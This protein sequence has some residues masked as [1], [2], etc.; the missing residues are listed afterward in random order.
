MDPLSDRWNSKPTATSYIRSRYLNLDPFTPSFLFLWNPQSTLANGVR[1]MAM[2]PMT[3]LVFGGLRLQEDV[4]L[5]LVNL[6]PP[7]TYPPSDRMVFHKAVLEGNQWLRAALII[8][9]LSDLRASFPNHHHLF[10][11]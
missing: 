5:W 1:R 3:V 6:P 8:G 2:L 11:E 9:G 7:Q 4:R 10:M